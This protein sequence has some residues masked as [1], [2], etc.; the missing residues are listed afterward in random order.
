MSSNSSLRSDSSRAVSGELRAENVSFAYA[1]PS[2]SSGNTPILRDL[3]FTAAPGTVISLVGPSGCGKSTFLSLAAGLMAPTEGTLYWEGEPVKLGP[4]NHLGMAFQQPG[5]F[6]WMTVER[7]ITVGLEVRGHKRAEA[8]KLAHDFLA[9]VGLADYARAYPR[10]LSGGMAQRVGI[11]RALALQPR[12]LL[13]DEPFASVDAF[14]RI[15]LQGEL[16]RMLELVQPTVILV[17]HDVSEA[18]TL[19][20]QVVVL[21]T[22]PAGIKTI[23]D[24]DEA[25]R[26]KSSPSYADKL[27]RIL[28]DLGVG[29][30]HR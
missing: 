1:N 11:A 3:T 17:T 21:S 7:N 30:A 6:P 15:T 13:L 16:R 20:D 27:S 25:D 19:G 18:I 22:R 5:L 28:E 23:I 2:A 8:K 29:E 14:T 24:I 9:K 26:D 4:T 10:Q 12:L